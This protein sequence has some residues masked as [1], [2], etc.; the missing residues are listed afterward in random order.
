MRV[1]ISTRSVK[2]VQAGTGWTSGLRLVDQI[3]GGLHKGESILE[4]TSEQF[5]VLYDQLNE[6]STKAANSATRVREAIDRKG[7]A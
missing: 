2:L 7:T 6:L 5:E 3:G 4:G 1:A